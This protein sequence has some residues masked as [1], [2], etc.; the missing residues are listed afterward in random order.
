MIKTYP[1][2][3]PLDIDVKDEIIEFTSH[4]DPYSDFNYISLF[5]WNTDGK[6]EVSILDGN[7]VIR[8]PDYITEEPVVSILGRHN[9]Q[10]AVSKLLTDVGSLKLVPE[11]TVLALGTAE[12]IEVE[13][14]PDN[15]DYIFLLQNIADLPGGNFKR[16]RNKLNGFMKEFGDNVSFREFN[17]TDS[18]KT[19]ELLECFDEWAE[20]REE[21]RHDS[22]LERKAIDRLLIHAEHFN[23]K[24]YETLLDEKIVGF[25]INEIIANEFALSHFHKTLRHDIDLD[26]YINSVEAKHLINE[27]CRFVNWEQDLGLEGLRRSKH[28][29]YPMKFLKKYQITKKQ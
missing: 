26:I 20:R 7:L 15:N 13:H 29:Y 5:S 23:L 16:K 9:I 2:F 12:S 18:Y 21:S 24:C 14:D 10:D 11:E 28:S 4:F 1:Q 17:I 27:G 22:D 3:S 8:I 25:S 6:A 19:K